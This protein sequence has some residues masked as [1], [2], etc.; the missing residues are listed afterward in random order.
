M[1]AKE[2]LELKHQEALKTVDIQKKKL[3]PLN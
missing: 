1:K 2:K 3:T